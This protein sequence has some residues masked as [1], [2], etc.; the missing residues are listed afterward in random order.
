MK[1]ILLALLSIFLLVSLVFGVIGCGE[2]DDSGEID[3][4]VENN[5]EYTI[6]DKTNSIVYEPTSVTPKYGLI[7]YVGTA[8]GYE[9]YEYLASALA[10]QGYLVVLPKVKGGLAYMLYNDNEHAFTDY[11]NVEFFVGGHSQGGGA[12]VR[13]A[14][15]NA[16]R[17]KGVILYAPLCYNDDSI[18]ELGL[19]TLLLEATKDGVLT[20]EMKADAKARLPVNRTEFMIDG[21]HMSFSSFDDDGTLTFFNDGPILEEVKQAQKNKTVEYTLAFLKNNL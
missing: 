13:R 2:K 5:F 17:V 18:K 6:N 8:I 16:Q 4:S 10:R 19:P 20:A 14:E 12:A 3:Y 15:E 21:C 7:F 1:R 9:Y 11:P